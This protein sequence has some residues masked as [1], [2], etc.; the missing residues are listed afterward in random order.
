MSI[1]S[2]EIMC[3]PCPKCELVKKFIT[4]SIKAIEVKNNIRIIYEFKH[5][6]NLIQASQYSV[7]ASQTPIVI[8]NGTVAFAGQV[9]PDIVK[10]KLESMHNY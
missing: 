8:I 4:E 2:I 1:K 6:P 9:T 7:N 5:T 10:K 3:I